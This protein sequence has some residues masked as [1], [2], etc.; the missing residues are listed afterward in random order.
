MWLGSFNREGWATSP[1]LSIRAGL[2]LMR[3]VL[4]ASQPSGCRLVL[5]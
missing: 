1:S 2:F 4:A 3:M 5:C